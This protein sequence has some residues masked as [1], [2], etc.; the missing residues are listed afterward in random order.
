M[1]G[2]KIVIKKTIYHWALLFFVSMMMLGCAGSALQ[3]YQTGSEEENAIKAT[4]LS[5][6][7]AWNDHNPSEILALLHEEFVV[8]T[9]RDR[10]IVYSKARYAFD[11]RNI[12]RR[13]RYLNFSQLTI[14]VKDSKAIVY[15][16]MLVDGRPVRNKFHM[17]RENGTWLFLDSEF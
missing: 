16:P 13:H 11:L 1:Q 4:L 15:A 14:W 10:R 17:I 9:G 2:N 7:K 12:M 3:G 5:Y 6:E 8:F